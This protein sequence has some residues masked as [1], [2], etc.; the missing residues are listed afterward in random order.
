MRSLSPSRLRVLVPLMVCAM[1]LVVLVYQVLDRVSDLHEEA[2]ES[3]GELLEFQMTQLQKSLS[4]LMLQND[5]GHLEERLAYAAL[6]RN[7]ATLL[8]ADDHDRV[9]FASRREWLGAAAPSVCRYDGRLAETCR[10]NL[11]GRL[12][13]LSEKLLGYYPIPLPAA[14]GEL[15]N[16]RYGTLYVEYDFSAPLAR[17]RGHAYG[18]GVRYLALIVL[19]AVILSLLIHVLIT[20]RIESLLAVVRAVAAGDMHARTG[21]SGDNELAQLAMAFDAMTAELALKQQRLHD[22]TLELEEEVAERQMT[23]ESLQEQ[24]ARLEEEVAERQ[25]AQEALRRSEQFLNMI[26]ETEPECVQLLDRQG[27]VL[28]VNRAGLQMFQFDSSEAVKGDCLYPLIEPEYREAYRELVAQVFRGEPGGLEYE[29]VGGRGERRWLDT[30]AAPFPDE[31]GEVTALVAITRDV[32]GKKRAEESI[33]M[34]S[35]AVNQ[36]PVSI[37]LTDTAGDITFVNPKFSQLTGYAREEVLGLN[38]RLLKSGEMTAG[39]YR[40]LWATISSGLVWD[41]ELQNRKKDGE[42]FWEHATISP[43]FTAKGTISHY[44]AIKEDVTER[45]LLEAQLFQAQ[46]MEAIGQLA[47]GVAHDFNNILTAII[48][49]SNLME[50]TMEPDDPKRLNVKQILASANKAAD[51]TRSLLTFSRKQA[52]NPQPVDL[53]QIVWRAEE[54]LQ[55]VIG[56]DVE[57]S[58]ALAPGS[59]TVNAD[60]G[61]IEQVLMNLATNARDA[62]PAGGRL[63]IETGSLRMDASFV[64]TH[65][66]GKPGGYARAS[67]SDTGEGMDQATCKRAFEPFFTTKEVGKGTGLG[68]SIVYGIVKQ[69]NGFLEVESRPGA[70]TTFTFYLPQILGSA[71]PVAEAEEERLGGGAET[72]L[73][74]DDD[75]PLRSLVEQTL[76]SAGYAVILAEDADT[77]VERFVRNRERI[78]LVVLDVIMPR[79]NGREALAEMKAVSPEVK[80]LFISGYTADILSRRTELDEEVAFIAK[81]FRPQQLLNKIRELLDAR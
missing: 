79:K 46:K 50:M 8:V 37:I 52:I 49:F 35:Q 81:P 23:Q 70:G 19:C 9:L 54:F 11:R 29:I 77:A 38:P 12:V 78:A 32:S 60:S 62:M 31:S 39:L 72:I 51:L 68:L 76:L 43:I 18:D 34:L 66:F 80:A 58:T 13:P 41:G 1:M 74:A 33:R 45:K 6:D 4:D 69:H 30:V 28:L 2:R 63:A 24:A 17:A 20:R 3:A 55:R 75:P 53:N 44:L 65:G 42:T 22:Q 16:R 59:L 25:Q 73:V 5:A 7:L 61:Q 14:P 48:G 67:V 47:G 57:L 21:I 15:R 27:R 56:E 40:E 64:K 26:I 36:S 71:L 10:L